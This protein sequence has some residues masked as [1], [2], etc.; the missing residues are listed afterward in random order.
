MYPVTSHSSAI[1]SVL[2][3]HFLVLQNEIHYF[4][5]F[6]L[7]FMQRTFSLSLS[8]H[9]VGFKKVGWNEEAEISLYKWLAGKSLCWCFFICSQDVFIVRMCVEVSLLL[10]LTVLNVGYVFI[11]TSR[12]ET[13]GSYCICSTS[14]TS[15]ASVIKSP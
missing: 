6:G 13:G 8:E 1:K 9:S 5:L 3:A 2:F 11:K 15:F 12:C 14:L 7:T 10:D 4:W